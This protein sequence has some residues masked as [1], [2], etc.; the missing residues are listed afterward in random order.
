MSHLRLGWST[1]PV[2]W[3]V[4]ALPKKALFQNGQGV[5]LRALRVPLV[6]PRP[7]E[8][9][10]SSLPHDHSSVVP[11][12]GTF[13]SRPRKAALPC[14]LVTGAVCH[15]HVQELSQAPADPGGR[16]GS[17][18]WQFHIHWVSRQRMLCGE[19]TH[20]IYI[21][22]YDFS[23]LALSSMVATSHMWPLKFKLIKIK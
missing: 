17:A 19:A 10:L 21:E 11:F 5:Q 12:A 23:R 3:S 13:T 20:S 1:H 18:Q 14:A 15:L 22:T 9:A 8:S 7:L 4:Q 2:S 16:V 6:S